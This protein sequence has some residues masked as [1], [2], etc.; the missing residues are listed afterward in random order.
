[1]QK[2]I[3]NIPFLTHEKFVSSYGLMNEPR[4]DDHEVL[5]QLVEWSIKNPTQKIYKHL[6]SRKE[7]NFDR[8]E[9]EF[10]NPSSNRLCRMRYCDL[11]FDLIIYHQEK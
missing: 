11:V 1:M 2:S 7:T 10:Y 9:G 8:Y 5:N 3:I 6:L 4:E